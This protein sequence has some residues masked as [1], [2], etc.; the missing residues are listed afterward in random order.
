MRLFLGLWLYFVNEK[1]G[2][3]CMGRRERS[4]KG[5]RYEAASLGSENTNLVGKPHT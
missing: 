1:G 5:R 4:E 2:K 3:V